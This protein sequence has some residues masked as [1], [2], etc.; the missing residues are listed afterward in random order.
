MVDRSGRQVVLRGVNARVQGLFDVTF[1]DGRIALQPIPEFTGE[2]CRFLS[3]QLGMNLLRLRVNWSGIEP[4]R[5]TWDEDYF[6]QIFQLVDDCYQH[7]V[8]TLVDLHQ[9]AYSKEIGEDGAPLWAIIPE[10]EELLEGPLD[11]LEQRRTSP[12]VLAAFQSLYANTDGVAEEYAEMAAE[13]ASRFKG[14]PG[15]IGLE[16][17]NEPV[18]PVDID[19]L[20]DFHR[21]VAGAIREA[22]P[23]LHM[24][25]E[26]DSLRNFTDV[27]S[28][29]EVFPFDNA[30]YAPHLY[31]DVFEDGWIDQDED[32]VAASLVAMFEE[33]E[34]HQSALLV[35]EW[36]NDIRTEHGRRYVEL[37]LELSSTSTLRAG[38]SGCTR[39]IPRTAG[40]CMTPVPTTPGAACERRP[41]T[42]WHVHSPSA[43]KAGSKAVPG[44][45]RSSPCGW[46]RARDGIASPPPHESGRSCPQRP[47]T[48]NP[49]Q[50]KKAHR[51]ASTRAATATCC[52]SNSQRFAASPIS[53]PTVSGRVFLVAA[54]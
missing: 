37:A 54:F 2:D 43:W 8:Y 47:A 32:K 31:T 33:A 42:S 52:S 20:D 13:L 15:A 19:A 38:P 46:S 7:D 53:S 50:S 22:A 12:Q 29:E 26:P 6:A 17:H 36:G 28:I 5:D 1:D 45:A 16:L 40:A 41:P 27:A 9:D 14:H 35:G 25:F 4:Q 23:E 18:S 11:D 44:T 30:T 39:S 48:D 24:A 21:L 34:E 10:P 49:L 51:A 3:E